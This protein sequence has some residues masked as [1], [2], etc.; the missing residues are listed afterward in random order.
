M[1]DFTGKGMIGISELLTPR[2]AKSCTETEVL[3]HKSA[4]R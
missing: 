4:K 1:C 3:E 2:E